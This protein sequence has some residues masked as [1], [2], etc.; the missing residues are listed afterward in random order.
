VVVDGVSEGLLKE[1]MAVGI[2]AAAAAAVVVVVVVAVMMAV[3]SV[4]QAVG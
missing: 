2:A 3:V 4:T 1:E